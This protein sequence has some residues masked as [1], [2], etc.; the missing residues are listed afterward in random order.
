[1]LAHHQYGIAP[2][3]MGSRYRSSPGKKS[4]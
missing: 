4:L 1:V 3:K 2:S